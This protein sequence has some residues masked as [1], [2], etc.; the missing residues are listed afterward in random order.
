MDLESIIKYRR[1][2]MFQWRIPVYERRMI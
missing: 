2:Y 1:I